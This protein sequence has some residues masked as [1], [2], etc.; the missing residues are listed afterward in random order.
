MEYKRYENKILVRVDKGEEIVENLISVCRKEDVRLGSV[1]GIGA[2][3]NA[4]IGLFDTKEKQYHKTEIK[5]DME[6]TPL[7]GN[8]TTMNGEVYLHLHINLGNREN[9]SFSGHLNSAVVSATFECVIDVFDG[10]VDREKD[11][12]VGLNLIKF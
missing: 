10:N 6:I 8:V 5:E 7:S 1:M 2:T 9:K 11:D 4:V 3:D 12:E